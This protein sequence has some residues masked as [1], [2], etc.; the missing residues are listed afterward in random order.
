MIESKIISDDLKSVKEFMNEKTKNGEHKLFTG[1]DSEI[2]V[3]QILN[4]IQELEQLSVKNKDLKLEN[5]V[6]EKRLRHL[7]QSKTILCFDDLNPFTREYKVDIQ[8]LDEMFSDAIDYLSKDMKLKLLTNC[9][10][11]DLIKG[12]ET[13]NIILEFK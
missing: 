6:L 8:K 5:E 4:L 13:G 2:K 10:L 1:D 3:V 7:F 12:I 9:F 11:E